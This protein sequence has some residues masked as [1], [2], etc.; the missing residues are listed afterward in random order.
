MD[1]LVFFQRAV[2][3]CRIKYYLVLNLLARTEMRC[4][5]Q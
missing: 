4:T 1:A 3:D 5:K 2:S